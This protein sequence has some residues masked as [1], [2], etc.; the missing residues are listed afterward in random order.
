MELPEA[1]DGKLPAPRGDEPASLRQDIVDEVSDHLQCSLDRELVGASDINQARQ[2][3]LSRFGKP[4]LIARQL[5][6]DW[7]KETMMMQRLLLAMSLAMMFTC[8][9]VG[10]VAWSV[11][12]KSQRTNHEFLEKLTN[13]SLNKTV[14][15]EQVKEW[16]PGKLRLVTS[17]GQPV[18]KGFSVQL[19]S[20]ERLNYSSD[21]KFGRVAIKNKKDGVFDLGLLRRRVY[22]ARITSSWNEQTTI[23]VDTRL[24]SSI[25]TT[26]VCPR[27]PLPKALLAIKVDWP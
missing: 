17:D 9:F 21:L 22:E 10:W 1:L 13:L 18:L 16:V 8:L 2:N 14:V 27:A 7:M 4:S 12:E 6:F 20:P 24:A 25:D 26:I 19:R 11:S 3:V 15:V 5:W 23:N